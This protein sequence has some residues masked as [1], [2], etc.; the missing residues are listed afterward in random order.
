MNPAHRTLRLAALTMVMF[1]TQL[2]I[3]TAD[4][5]TA[6]VDASAS[7]ETAQEGLAKPGRY[8]WYDAEADEV[9]RIEVKPEPE[10]RAKSSGGF[11]GSLIQT[12]GWTGIGV[13]LL[14][15]AMAL[16]FAFLGRETET[17]SVAPDL[18]E[19][20]RSDVDRM[21]ALP[22]KVRRPASDLLSE[23]RRCFK[24]GDYGEAIIYLYSHQLLELDRNQWV[25]LTA[26]KTNR[27]Y[28]WELAASMPL[29]NALERTMVAFED[30][31][32][33]HHTIDRL[34]CEEC[35]AQLESFDRLVQ[36]RAT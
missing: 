19:D 33:G 34:R 25:H 6:A 30:A 3:A 31:F 35:F 18:E 10:A 24:R 2:A 15:I 29:R 13:L 22:F 26:G 23:A 8:P 11:L 21:E 20:R 14:V 36:Q 7:V 27:Q 17:V 12:L 28:L 1:A 32:F 5:E 4:E 9:R 16:I